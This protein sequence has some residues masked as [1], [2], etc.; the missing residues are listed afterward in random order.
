MVSTK[1]SDTQAVFFRLKKS[2]IFSPPSVANSKFLIQI[3]SAAEGAEFQYLIKK[4]GIFLAA[5]GGE[6]QHFNPDFLIM[7]LKRFKMQEISKRASIG[8]PSDYFQMLNGNGFF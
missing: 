2:I 5:V 7:T 3:F 1:I 6:F 8:C 4:T